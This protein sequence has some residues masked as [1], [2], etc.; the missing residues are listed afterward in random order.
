MIL[1]LFV[2][3]CCHLFLFLHAV[4]HHLQTVTAPEL[5]DPTPNQKITKIKIRINA[6]GRQRVL[7]VKHWTSPPYC[8]YNVRIENCTFS[9]VSSG[10]Q[11]GAW[12]FAKPYNNKF[13]AVALTTACIRQRKN[14][15][16]SVLN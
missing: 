10:W 15:R 14:E 13:A 12:G 7:S 11:K 5:F 8:L 6:R 9:N 2:V 1:F 3:A 16:E 4:R